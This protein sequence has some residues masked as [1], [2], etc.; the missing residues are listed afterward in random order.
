MQNFISTDKNMENSIKTVIADMKP[1]LAVADT[2][3]VIVLYGGK[4][5]EDIVMNDSIIVKEISAMMKQLI[6]NMESEYKVF[7]TEQYP[8]EK[9][10]L[11]K[12]GRPKKTIITDDQILPAPKESKAYMFD[13]SNPEDKETA[14][15]E[16]TE[17]EV[18]TNG[19][20]AKR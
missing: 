11:R 16:K 1:R 4:N 19:D 3:L 18:K 7:F 17:K 10:Q 9:V 20:D 2:D 15:N 5:V 8:E 6:S 13:F 14:G 12:R